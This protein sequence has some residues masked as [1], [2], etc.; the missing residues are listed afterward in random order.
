ML[1][2]MGIAVRSGRLCADTV[3]Q[4]YGVTGTIRASFAVYNT[5]D[6]IDQF[7]AALKK[8]VMMLG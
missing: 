1:D 3:M 2:K 4:H 7:V 8:L 5:F 6:E